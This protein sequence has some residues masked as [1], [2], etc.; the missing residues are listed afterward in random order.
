[1]SK[2]VCCKFV[3]QSKL[4]KEIG[5]LVHM[6]S[7][8]TKFCVHFW[9]PLSVSLFNEDSS[10]FSLYSFILTSVAVT[11]NLYCSLVL[12]NVLYSSFCV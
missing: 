8:N 10:S 1:M 4:K 6:L 9:K 5:I 12:N 7:K 2:P 11:D 3:N